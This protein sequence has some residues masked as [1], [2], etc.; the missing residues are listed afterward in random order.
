M[1]NRMAEI[2]APPPPAVLQRARG[3]GVIAVGARGLERL[4]Q[5]G[6][7]KLRLV[8]AG[9]GA[10]R[11]GLTEAVVI[12]SSGGVTGGDRLELRARAGAGAALSLSTQAAERGYRARPREAPAQVSNRLE[13]GPGARLDWL[14]QETILF[15]GAR[16]ERRLEVDMAADARLLACEVV[17]LGRA[18][19]GEALIRLHLRD[20][21][22]IRRAGRLI[23]ADST[24][25]DLPGGAARGRGG[26]AGIGAWANVV[27]AAPGAEAHLER[28][29]ALLAADLPGGGPEGGVESGASAIEGLVLVRLLAADAQALR[30]RLMAV[31]ELL[32]G[33]ALP[34]VWM[35]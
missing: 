12:N 17:V 18:A 4:H 6:C 20:H 29:R 33:V 2:S 28:L 27:L 24:G 19:M 15:D 22:R 16:L 30:I 8:R 5:Q 7:V 1:A 35:L 34:R 23:R 26:L 21:W 3:R 9:A 25:L 11:A 13:L 14:P 31:L 10:G 32:R